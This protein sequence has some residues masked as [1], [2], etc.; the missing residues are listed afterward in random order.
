MHQ[1]HVLLSVEARNLSM[2]EVLAMS[3]EQAFALFRKV[4]WGRD[5]DPVCPACGVVERH[6]LLPSR[7]QRRC[8]ACQHTFS[9][10]SG[11]IFAHYRL[12][13]QVYLGAISIDTHAVKRL[14]ELQ[15]ARGIRRF[16]TRP[17]SS[18]CTSCPRA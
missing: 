17:R 6:W 13:L 8:R 3:D 15:M 11:T 18:R 7:Q 2:R 5:A 10:T 1:N 12:L 4:S 9:A 14:S 16:S